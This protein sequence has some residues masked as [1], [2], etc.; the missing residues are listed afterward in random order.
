M[1]NVI[2]NLL[3]LV[4]ILSLSSSI[5]KAQ[6][7]DIGTKWTYNKN[8]GAFPIPPILPEDLIWTIE[9]VGDTL[10]NGQRYLVLEGGCNTA[11]AG[12]LYRVDGFKHFIYRDGQKHLLYDFSVSPGEVLTVAAPMLEQQDSVSV[13]V[14]N[15][16]V[17]EHNGEQF[18][19]QVMDPYIDDWD[20]HADW[21]PRFMEHVGSLDFCLFPQHGLVGGIGSGLRCIEFAD[22][23]SIK[24]TEDEFC[25]L[26]ATSDPELSFAKVFPNPASHVLNIESEKSIKS[27]I[28]YNAN[29]RAVI[30]NRDTNKVSTDKLP[31]GMYI[32]EINYR[33]GKSE[34]TKVVKL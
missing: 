17:E 24:F 23:T 32:L 16:E 31:S 28:V 4:L 21:G 7:I 11:E 20:V 18:L 22:G 1:K 14:Q 34:R 5:A 27:L 25:N 12:F 10:V 29:G 2:Y 15:L 33:N 6:K 13:T 30:E 3:M 19:V 8:N 26:V 9:I